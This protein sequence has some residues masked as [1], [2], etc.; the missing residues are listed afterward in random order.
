[1]FSFDILSSD[2]LYDKLE[3]E[4]SEFSKS[5][6]SSYCAINYAMTAW[7]IIDWLYNEEKESSSSHIKFDKFREDIVED[8]KSLLIM[9]DIANGTKHAVVTRYKPV[10]QNSKV[11]P[12][13]FEQ[14][15]FAEGLFEGDKL[16]IEL[17]NGEVVP[18]ESIVIE[19]MNFWK[20]FF[21]RE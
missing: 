13:L 2:D 12:G 4:F 6:S 18:F 7:H 5:K 16:I 1:M 17:D 10:I 14:G 15:L 19:T 3:F 21:N 9:G 8:C 11:K 20:K